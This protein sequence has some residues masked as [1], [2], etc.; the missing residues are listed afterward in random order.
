MDPSPRI[1]QMH[2][3][4]QALRPHL[5]STDRIESHVAGSR[6][7]TMGPMSGTVRL[8]RHPDVA[9]SPDRTR[10]V[11]RPFLPSPSL[12][13]DGSE[14]I[15]VTLERL[16]EMSEPEVRAQLDAVDAEFEGRHDPADMQQALDDHFNHVAG[17]IDVGSLTPDHRRLIALYVTHE[18]SIEGAGLGN[19]SMVLAPDQQ[20][21][22]PGEARVVL[23]LRS[24]GEGHRS[25]I[26]FRTG[27]LGREPSFTAD[28][29]GNHVSTGRRSPAIYEREHFHRHLD[30]HSKL[31][32]F[33]TNVLDSLDDRFS[34]PDLDTA[35]RDLSTADGVV[36]DEEVARLLVRLADSNYV[37]E[38]DP[39]R[40][41]SE[42]VLFPSGPSESH[43]MEDAR[44]VRFVDDDG[45][46][47]YYGT[48]TAFDGRDI[49]PQLIETDD[50][51]RF[52][53]S[54]LRGPAAQNKG[55]ALFPRKIGGE[56]VA[57]GRHDNVNNFVMRSA[58]IRQWGSA[59][60]IQEPNQ[61]WELTQLG[62]CGSPIETSDGWLVITHGVGAMRRYTLGALLLDTDDP[63]K[64][65]GHAQY[66]IL[67][68][69]GRE[70]DGYVPNVVYSC[71]S[72]VHQNHL[73][74]PYG[75]SDYGASM[76]S[77]PLDEIIGAMQ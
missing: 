19:P 8:H 20:G 17:R 6:S 57:L 64:V 37:V 3:L 70:R 53:I 75:Y 60:V 29:V 25:S 61:P 28:P 27:V 42:R 26:S 32:D 10:V 50:F 15:D 44:L 40:G 33:A 14:R 66:P 45:R 11:L 7:D 52:R 55:I 18:Y 34:R 49:L 58:S 54:T 59:T 73:I 41:A 13:F 65:I 51:V 56:Y 62:N 43:G 35:I 77:V 2:A 22:G 39:E 69:N 71:G 12:L 48:Y 30:E 1:L 5:D 31:N 36:A 23:S 9:F 63:T 16:L 76:A 46:I 4:A 67:E 21:V 74:I 24:I 68:P 38:F 72:L 47:T